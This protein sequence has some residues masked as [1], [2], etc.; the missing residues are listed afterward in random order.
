MAFAALH[1]ERVRN[2]VVADTQV[3]ALQP[4]VRLSEWSYYG[5]VGK[6]SCK[7]LALSVDLPSDKSFISHKLLAKLSQRPITI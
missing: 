5:P 7:A 3:R 4:P 1:P 2:L 6:E